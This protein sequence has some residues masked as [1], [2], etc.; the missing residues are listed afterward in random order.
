MRENKRDRLARLNKVEHLLYQ[1]PEGM[2]IGAIAEKCGVCPRTSRR[3]LEAL[4]SIG[5]PVWEKGNLRGILEDHF[6]PPI[7]FTLPE[8]MTVFLAARLMLAYS[9]TYNPNIDSTFVKLNSAVPAPL[10]DQVRRTIDWMQK[11]NRDDRLR[12]TTDLLTQAWTKGH[13]ARISY[14]ALGRRSAGVRVIEPYF[15]Q[16][17]TFEHA[18]YLIAFCCQARR[19]RTFKIDR[20]QDIALLDEHYSIPADF[21][22]NKFLAPAWGITLYGKPV[23]VKLRFNS[24]IARLALETRWHPSQL[25][26]TQPD[27]SAVA[28][29]KVPVTDEYIAFVMRWGDKVEVLQPAELRSK[30]AHTARRMMSMYKAVVIK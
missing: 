14:Q 27:G 20:I 23:A 7:S 30:V 11:L 2:T 4:E 1:C 9:N 5:V 24:E 12:R 25:V 16:P 19:V 3:D 13:K 22:A 26:K 8:A 17:A 18:N 6:L 28:T 10:Q 29:F 21:D 15:I